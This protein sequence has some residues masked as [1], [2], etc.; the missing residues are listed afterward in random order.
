MN[1]PKYIIKFFK[2]NDHEKDFLENEIFFTNPVGYY[3]DGENGQSDKNEASALGK[4]LEQV[5]NEYYVSEMKVGSGYRI[6]CCYAVYD[7][8]ISNGYIINIDG[9][10][11]DDF[12]DN[13]KEGIAVLVEWDEFETAI[14]SCNKIKKYEPVDYKE[15][16]SS[17]DELYYLTDETAAIFHKGCYYSYQKEFRIV[18]N[19]FAQGKVVLNEDKTGYKMSYADLSKKYN[20]N[21]CIKTAKK[22]RKEDFIE[23]TNGLYKIRIS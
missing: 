2:E 1:T 3:W 17:D 19:D 18:F 13:P 11:F 4:P 6:F 14:K 15:I 20:Y 12:F 22:Y 23:T 8:D 10:C 5:H 16:T 9:R 21:Y 7:E